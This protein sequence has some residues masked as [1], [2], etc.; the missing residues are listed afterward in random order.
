MYRNTVVATLGVCSLLWI[1]LPSIAF[2]QDRG[3]QD[4][5]K[6][7]AD[8]DWPWWRGP[9]RNGFA[10]ASNQPPAEFS[11]AK[12]V[13]W[14]VDV[15]GRGHSSPV[16]VGDLVLLATADEKVQTQWVLAFDKSTGKSAWSRQLSEGGFPANNHAKNTEATPTVACDGVSIFATFFHHAQVQLSSLDL[17]G[18]VN[19]QV[20]IGPFNPKRYE[21]GYAPSPL[22]YR[23][24]VIMSAEHDGESYI[25]AHDRKTGKQVWKTPRQA[26]IT[27]SSPVIANIAGR[28]QLM[29][30]GAETVASY[31][32][33]NG[34]QLWQTQATTFATCGT[35]VW[36][37]DMVFASGGYPEPGTYGIKGTSSGAEVVWSNREKCYE[38]SMIVV[39]DYLY[40]LTDNGIMFCW[41]AMTGEEKWKKRLS[42]PVSASP[43]YANG[44]IYWA[45]EAGRYFVFKPSPMKYDQVAA[46][47]LGDEAFASPAVS[48]NA[49]FLRGAE[50]KGRNRQEVLYCIEE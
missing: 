13:K 41:D 39:D 28:D 40:G 9:M 2:G 17:T 3:I 50:M 33:T 29:I 19:W 8:S 15:P 20:N 27:F 42:G 30:S 11:N 35:I 4:F 36:K 1:A 18:K 44:L 12:N 48:G 10:A 32:P 14:K 6:L 25:V 46:N 31:D 5:P 7:S 24:T 16:V 21:Y 26:N 45:N 38:Q 23:D 34:Q 37:D 49:L 22:L 43:V 47:Q